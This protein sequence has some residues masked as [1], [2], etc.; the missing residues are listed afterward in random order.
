MKEDQVMEAVWDPIR[1]E[2]LRRLDLL[3]T[4]AEEA[5]DRLT[6][7][8][9]R[10][11]GSPVSLVSLVDTDRQFFKSLLGLPEPAAT[12]RQTPLS[13]SFCKHVVA[14]D[15]ALIVEDARD[16]P[17]LKDNLAIPHLGVIGYLG[18][19]LRTTDGVTLGSFCVIDTRPRRWLPEEIEIIRDLAALTMTEI[20]LR[21]ENKRRREAEQQVASL[22]GM[23][24][25]DLRTPLTIIGGTLELLQEMA[26]RPEFEQQHHDLIANALRSTEKM[27][28]LVEDILNLS[29]SEAGQLA[30]ELEETDL[31]LFL[32]E[33]KASYLMQADLERKQFALDVAAGLPAVAVDRRL[34]ARVVDNLIGN[35]FK[36]SPPGGT[37]ELAVARQGDEI[38]VSV[39]DEGTGVAEAERESI[40]EKY[41][42]VGDERRPGQ[43]SG[44]GIGLAFCQHVVDLH[45]GRIWVESGIEKGSV[46][47]FALPLTRV[48]DPRGG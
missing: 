26:G 23:I 10:I 42:Q 18:M 24:L 3:D 16:H 44:V 15:E 27:D 11:T 47:T 6:R 4:P 48:G 38:L 25:H 5:F 14:A 36:Y 22:T 2:I 28:Y 35:A 41:Y 20:E 19:P 9:S 29:K 12:E 1:L 33:M 46:F 7:L 31:P 8:A 37:V 17:L 45:R 30:L 21:A 40:F 32:E 34:L 13:H 43:R 39:R